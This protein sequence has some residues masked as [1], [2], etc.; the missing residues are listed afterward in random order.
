MKI[1]QFCPEQLYHSPSS[2]Y[3]S[4]KV[5]WS[6]TPLDGKPHRSKDLVHL[7]SY[8]CSGIQ[9]TLQRRRFVSC[10]ERLNQL[11]RQRGAFRVL[12]V[13]TSENK[14]GS[15]L[16]GTWVINCRKCFHMLIPQDNSGCQEDKL[17]L[18]CEQTGSRSSSLTGG[19]IP[20][21]LRICR[22]WVWEGKQGFQG[23]TE[24]CQEPGEFLLWPMPFVSWPLW[25]Q[26]CP[27]R[28]MLVLSHRPFSFESRW[29]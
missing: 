25:L 26:W 10:Q 27:R 14:E 16:F 12:R 7:L 9:Q 13:K 24:G 15:C 28:S 17:R 1:P 20:T 23:Q 29:D 11:M 19:N 4:S 18:Q 5:P 3:C 22:G 2:I 6:L 8:Q 21:L